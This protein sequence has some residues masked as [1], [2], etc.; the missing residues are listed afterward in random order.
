MSIT[1]RQLAEWVQGEVEGD[2]DLPIKSARPLDEAGPGDIT[3]ASDQRRVAELHH[4]PASAAVVPSGTPANGK[5]L[6]R[7]HDPLA[8]FAIIFAR[9]SAR[10]GRIRSKHSPLRLRSPDGRNRP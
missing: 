2:G 3:F 8:A 6:I 5:P 4:C 7:V 1:L 9:F 10:A